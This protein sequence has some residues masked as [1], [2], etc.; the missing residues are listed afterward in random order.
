MGNIGNIG[1]VRS[2]KNMKDEKTGVLIL[3]FGAPEKLED[4]EAFMTHICHGEKP[5]EQV[6]NIVKKKYSSLGGGSPLIQTT[7]AQAKELELELK[8]QG[9]DY[10]V[11]VGML[12]S[13][14]LIFDVVRQMLEAGIKRILAVSMA[15]FYSEVSTGAYFSAVKEAIF[16]NAF[17]VSVSFGS[18]WCNHPAFS[19][20]WAK[21]IAASLENFTDPEE[22][23]LIFTTHSLPMEPLEDALVYQRQYQRVIDAIMENL[24][25]EK[26]YIAFQSK[27]MRRGN[28]LS[29]SVEDVLEKLIKE[30]EKTV[31]LAPVGFVADHMETLYDLD[32]EIK[33]QAEK[34]SIDFH[35][36][37]TFNAQSDFIKILAE[38]VLAME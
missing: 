21:K 23:N 4:V 20:A 28:W 29:P 32:I 2:M 35:R 14:P 13:P 3:N 18:S 15:P 6:L 19:L 1:N 8:R 17:E 5:T 9:K 27:G 34:G 16:N 38:M 7:K 25:H 31:L 33:K 10:S 22:V 11:Y 36:I 30:G 24:T 37:T 26:V 12:H